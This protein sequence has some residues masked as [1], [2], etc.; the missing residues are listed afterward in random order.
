MGAALAPVHAG[1]REA[2]APVPAGGHVDA[3]G[4]EALGTGRGQVVRLARRV[5]FAACHQRGGDRHRQLAGEVVVARAGVLEPLRVAPLAQRARVRAAGRGRRERLEDRGEPGVGQPVVAVPSLGPDGHRARVEQ[6]G[7]VPGHGRG[8]YAGGPGELAGGVR[9]AAD[10]QR[11]G[12][13]AGAVGE[14]AGDRDDVGIHVSSIAEAS[15]P[16]GPGMRS[17]ADVLTDC[18]PY[19]PPGDG[20]PTDRF[21]RSVARF[22]PAPDH[23]HRRALATALLETLDPTALRRA[24][25][26]RATEAGDPAEPT[27]LRR[28]AA[29][30][31]ERPGP[32]RRRASAAEGHLEEVV[33]GVLAEVLGFPASVVRLVPGIAAAYQ[34]GEAD[35]EVSAALEVLGPGEEEAVAARLMVLVQACAATA[36]LAREAATR[37][38]TPEEAV[39]AALAE[40]PPVRSTRR[41][42]PDGT[43]TAV[44][45]TALPFGAGPHRCPGEP[46]ARAL[47]AGL[48]EGWRR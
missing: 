24:A 27:T 4:G 46:H 38:G 8:R 13:G 41:V 35:A 6:L 18:A 1:V 32:A 14:Q 12:G 40:A 44:D 7:Q 43:V 36:A 20:G 22:S 48:V 15:R 30:V 39:A 28:A 5:Q 2:P 29:A 16:Y 25:A 37:P 3:R 21:R 11:Q 42:C 26:G 34:G 10:Q 9:G 45:L 17:A 31:G 33:V 19:L 23:P 47:A